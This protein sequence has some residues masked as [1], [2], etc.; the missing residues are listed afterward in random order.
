MSNNRIIYPN[1]TVTQT[2]QKLISFWKRLIKNWES[3]LKESKLHKETIID[4]LENPGKDLSFDFIVF[5]SYIKNCLNYWSISFFRKALIKMIKN[6]LSLKSI[7]VFSD[8]YD[9]DQRVDYDKKREA[10][11]FVYKDFSEITWYM[12]NENTKSTFSSFIEE[13]VCKKVAKAIKTQ[14]NSWHVALKKTK[15]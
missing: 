2:N 15:I 1:D 9:F 7:D 10:L 12:P 3:K 6:D 8:K 11:Q 5:R 4:L 14:P 13:K